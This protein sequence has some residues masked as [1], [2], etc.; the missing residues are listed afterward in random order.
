MDCGAGVWRHL[1]AFFLRLSSNHSWPWSPTPIGQSARATCRHP[2]S[3]ACPTLSG[4]LGTAANPSNPS[5]SGIAGRVIA[6]C[7]CGPY[8]P[9][10]QRRSVS[11]RFPPSSVSYLFDGLLSSSVGV[12]T[13]RRKEAACLRSHCVGR[14]RGFLRF[15]AV[16][17]RVAADFCLCEEVLP[18]GRHWNLYQSQSFCGLVGN[19]AAIYS[20]PWIALGRQTAPCSSAQRSKGAQPL[21]RAGT[22][23]PGLFALP[24][25]RSGLEPWSPLCFS[26]VSSE[27]LLGWEA[28]PWSCA[29]RFLDRNTTKPAR[30][31]YRSGATPLT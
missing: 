24:R 18:G 4:R 14:V 7:A 16:S 11:N 20:S 27:L 25:C 3:V 8:R 13:Q 9:Y 26:S 17:D 2:F 15:G 21:I 1:T 10:A 12:R 19:G 31:A 30:I 23:S 6:L 28:I 5:F 22:A 29:L